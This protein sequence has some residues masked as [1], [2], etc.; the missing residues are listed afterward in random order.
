VTGVD[1]A[2]VGDVALRAVVGFFG[3]ADFVLELHAPN[4]SATSAKVT[5]GRIR[6]RPPGFDDG[7]GK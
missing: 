6:M 3:A 2:E 7:A 5:T 4:S 1:P